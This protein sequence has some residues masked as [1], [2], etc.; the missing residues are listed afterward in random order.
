MTYRKSTR[1]VEAAADEAVV[2][3]GVVAVAAEAE[4][5]VDRDPRREDVASPTPALHA[6]LRPVVK[7]VDLRRVRAI[8]PL[9]DR[10]RALRSD[11]GVEIG[12]PPEVAIDDHSRVHVPRS[13]PARGLLQGREPVLD[14]QPDRAH[15]P[16]PAI[17]PEGVVP[18]LAIDPEAGGLVPV[19]GPVPV[20][21][22]VWE[23]D[24]VEG[25]RA[26]VTDSADPALEIVHRN[27][28]VLVI[29]RIV[30]RTGWPIVEIASAIAWPT[31][32]IV[33]RT[34]A[35]A[36]VTGTIDTTATITTGI[37]VTGMA[38]GDRVRAG[39]TGGTGIP[40]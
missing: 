5:R 31:T 9:P 10:A 26:A 35:I 3:A 34:V 21:S 17:D 6:L 39:I 28:P 11:P 36:G 13:R 4:E 8:V 16:E 37:T 24:P 22:Q 1:A 27:V 30:C 14:Q 40:S 29:D 12:L 33:I 7:Q 2:P 20:L 15:A 23:V 32:A 19:T 18:A 25:V 38:T